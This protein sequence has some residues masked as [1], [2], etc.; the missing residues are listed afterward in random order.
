MKLGGWDKIDWGGLKKQRYAIGFC[1]LTILAVIL[2]HMFWSGPLMKER[3]QLEAQVERERLLIG[4]YEEKLSN[5]EKVKVELLA[6]EKELQILREKLVRTDDPYKLAASL[7]ETMSKA[8]PG[9]TV[10]SYQVVSAKENEGYN[11]AKLQFNLETDI[12]GLHHFLVGIKE[13]YSAIWVEEVSIRSR[14]RETGSRRR[15]DI[16]LMTV[17]VTLAALM[18]KGQ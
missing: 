14:A 3:R 11:E 6:R 16:D 18:E 8:S 13:E 9:L 5:A 2:A 17:R 12:A 7:G 4:K 10:K 1:V 15:K